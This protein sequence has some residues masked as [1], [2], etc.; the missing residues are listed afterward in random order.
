MEMS[1]IVKE[2][3][4]AEPVRDVEIHWVSGGVTLCRSETE[5]ILIQQKAAS[6]LPESRQMKVRLSH[7]R[8][9]IEE[10]QRK[11]HLGFLA[12][13]VQNTFL[14]LY[15]PAKLLDSLTIRSVSNWVV[16]NEVESN[17]LSLSIVSGNVRLEGR[18]NRVDGNFVSGSLDLAFEEMPLSI[19][20]ENVSGSGTLRLPPNDGIYLRQTILSGGVDCDFPVLSG[21]AGG[22]RTEVRIT[23]VSSQFKI[24]QK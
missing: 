16:G 14:Y 2:F 10:E 11:K 6:P 13:R 3:R 23:G 18:M 8:L 22:G 21:G 19:E 9:L 12:A 5:E 20:L 24:E 15:L 4:S 1:K 7:G 17:R